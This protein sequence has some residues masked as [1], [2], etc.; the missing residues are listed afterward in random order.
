MS[1]YK[2]YCK[3]LDITDCYIGSSKDFNRRIREHKY[4][5]TITN[6]KLKLYNFIREH[7]G[8]DNWDF[9]CI[10]DNID[11]NLL[12]YREKYW[13]KYL[14]P[15]LNIQWTEKNYKCEYCENILA[16]ISNLNYHKK[17]NKKCIA[18]RNDNNNDNN[19]IEFI[20]KECGFITPLKQRSLKHKCR[21]EH[22]EIYKKYL[23]LIN[24]EKENKNNL[25][26]SEEKIKT[27]EIEYKNN[28]TKSEDKIKTIEIEYK[29]KL[30][31]LKEKYKLLKEKQEKQ[32][33]SLA[34]KCTNTN[35]KI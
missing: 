31:K 1:V 35:I 16:S 8:I 27:I 13:I 32:I 5:I 19:K 3:N 15:T 33:F 29:N 26:K 20:C 22:V 30:H 34:S 24:T 10:E 2:I 7:G 9:V 25:T 28:L 14:K 4:T 21:K 17:T 23:N 11:Y 18:L 12:H 6:Y